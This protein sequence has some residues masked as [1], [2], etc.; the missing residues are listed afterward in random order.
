[1]NQIEEIINICKKRMK[2]S[3]HLQTMCKNKESMKSFEKI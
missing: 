2:F 3:I 1:M